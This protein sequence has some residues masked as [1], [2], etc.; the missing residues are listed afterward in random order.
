M[1][2]SSQIQHM[3]GNCSLFTF[4]CQSCYYSPVPT[5]RRFVRGM[6]IN[7]VVEF[8]TISDIFML[9][10]WGLIA[11]ILAIFITDQVPG[12][13]IELVGLSTTVYFLT[14][15]VVQIPVARFI[16]LKKGEWDDYWTMIIGSLLISLTA[17]IYIFVHTAGQVYLAQFIY[18]LG[19]A[20]SYPSWL[21]I[22]TKHIDKKEEAFEWSV[23]YT[24]TD[25]GAA[26]TA[27][28]G[29]FIAQDFGYKTLFFVVGV[30]SLVGTLFL[31]QIGNKMKKS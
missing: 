21:A 19:G 18:G 28:L 22:F 6:H 12:G 11:P 25:I 24:A 4:N 27:G 15:S 2:S 9:S 13:T 1:R 26:L 14:K 16:D 7:R 23:Y 17:F 5:F 3:S 30:M 31:A 8:L 29:G 10:G 20:L